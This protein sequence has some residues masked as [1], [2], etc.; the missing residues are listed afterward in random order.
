[1]IKTVIC[2]LKFNGNSLCFY[3]YNPRG[4]FMTSCI[5]HSMFLFPMVSSKSDLKKQAEVNDYITFYAWWNEIR[6][7]KYNYDRY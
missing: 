3:F 1:M 4:E 7:R 6:D 5:N 2:E